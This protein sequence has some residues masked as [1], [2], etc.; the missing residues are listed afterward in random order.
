MDSVGLLAG[1]IAHDFNNI[2]IGIVG[3]VSLLALG[4]HDEESALLLGEVSRAC[5]QA[6]AL[7]NQL[8]TF[9]QGGSPVREP[10]LLPRLLEDTLS[11]VLRGSNVV[12]VCDFAPDLHRAVLDRGQIGQVIQNIVINAIQA[13]P[14][15][16]TIRI[17]ATNVPVD[18]TM[19]LPLEPGHY[20]RLAFSDSGPGICPEHLQ[21]IFD[22]YFTTKPSGHG[23]GLATS[24]SI[25]R[26]HGGHI[27]VASEVGTGT[28]FE[29]YLPASEE[30]ELAEPTKELATAAKSSKARVLMMD[31][32]DT[33]LAVGTKMLQFSGYAASAVAHDGEEAI[34]LCQEALAEGVPFTVAIMDLTIPGGMG[35]KEA[36]RR[37]R[38]LDPDLVGVVSSGYSNDPVMANYEAHGFAAVLPKPYRLTELRRAMERAVATQP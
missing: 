11:F 28:T 17:S 32:E 36:F 6:K 15:G 24:Y 2:L 20:V 5:D 8:L 4:E 35:G 16:G 29:L 30:G 38:D 22:P 37:L 3:N 10:T 26:K 7:N 1:G 25:L 14:Q 12:S 9:S 34:R 21:R 23:L 33:V 13:M 18:P 19:P 27:E 31:D